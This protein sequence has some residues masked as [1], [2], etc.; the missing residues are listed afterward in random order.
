MKKIIENIDVK[1]CKLT[2][3]IPKSKD[4][5]FEI[6]YDEYR[7]IAFVYGQNIVLKSRNGV[8]L[9]KKFENV[10]NDLKNLNKNMILDGEICCF[11]ENGR[12]DFGLLQNS[13]KQNKQNFCYV[14]FDL[15]ELNYRDLRNLTLFE[16]KKLLEKNLKNKNSIL[17]CEFATKC[18]QKIFDFAKEN[19]LEGIVAKNIYS[20]YNSCRDENWLKIKCEKR[21]E[22]VI[23]GFKTTQKND[24]L[25]AIFVGYYDKNN[26][27]CVGKVGTGFNEKVKK[28]LKEK[29]KK[30]ET[31]TCK[32]KNIE[33]FKEDFVF[34]KPK[35]VVEIKFRE[36]TKDGKLRQASFVGLRD[37]KNAKNVVFESV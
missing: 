5:I 11:D 35:L 22:F 20:T 10:A 33:K 9:T 36:I 7:T 25:S 15:L 16:R 12:S 24:V 27:I 13:I 18:G 19:N 21:Q 32:I 37:D 17:V 2:N 31:K 8:D 4:Y 30:L 3:E 29:F 34:L 1:L 6:K 28:S 23:V 26:L 14:V